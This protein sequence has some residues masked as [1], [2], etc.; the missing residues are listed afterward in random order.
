MAGPDPPLKTATLWLI[1]GTVQFFKWHYQNFD[2]F[3]KNSARD[4]RGTSDFQMM[5]LF[6]VETS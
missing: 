2:I 3:A 1:I 6:F 5:L 4:S